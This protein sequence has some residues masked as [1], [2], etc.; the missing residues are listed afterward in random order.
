MRLLYFLFL[1]KAKKDDV[2]ESNYE[3][4]NTRNKV[5]KLAT[6]FNHIDK[7]LELLQE[8]DDDNEN[9]LKLTQGMEKVIGKY[10]TLY[11][12]LKNPPS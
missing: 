7:A 5:K 8:V 3:K 10:K 4:S 6:A 11:F 2:P 1:L 9:N 12:N